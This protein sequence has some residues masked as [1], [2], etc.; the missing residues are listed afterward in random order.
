MGFAFRGRHCQ[1]F[2]PRQRREWDALGVFFCR[3]ALGRRCQDALVVRLAVFQVD[4]VSR[5]REGESLIVWTQMRDDDRDLLY[6][7]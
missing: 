3:A 5:V 6:G 7:E 4:G 1:P 2:V